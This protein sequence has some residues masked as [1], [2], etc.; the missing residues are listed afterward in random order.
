MNI[1][2]RR[3]SLEAIPE[4]I[5]LHRTCFPNSPT[6]S[7]DYFKWLYS[8]NPAGNAVGADAW[9][10]DVLV[11][12]VIAVPASYVLKDVP[13]NGVLA[14]N[15]AVHPKFQ[16]RLLFK[17]LG[18]EMC[19]YAR[20]DGFGFVIGVANR[21]ATPGWIRHMGFQLVQPLDAVV[22]FGDLG[23]NHANSMPF[24][25]ELR[26]A[27]SPDAL[28]WRLKNPKNKVHLVL[29]CSSKLIKTFASSGTI[30][31]SA[32]AELPYCDQ[33]YPFVPK[34]KDF[35]LLP[36][37]FLGLIPNHEFKSNYLKIPDRY[38]PSPLNLIY[39][40]LIDTEDKITPGSCFI[41]FLD[42]DAF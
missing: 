33:E 8:E 15:V 31:L 22:G 27:W 25:I 26:H 38:K 18:L 40:N 35:K 20:E 41:N 14:V 36:R 23:I 42:F 39:K 5:N 13:V 19:E 12:Q 28:K 4:Y 9:C 21:Q 11:G 37:V 34:K 6:P 16:G 10:E 3:S 32:Y 2:I 24:P 7:L 30:G 29:D 1:V 17:K